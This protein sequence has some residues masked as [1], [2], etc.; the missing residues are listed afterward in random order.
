[1]TGFLS[2]ALSRLPTYS[3]TRTFRFALVL[4]IGCASA[5][6]FP[7]KAQ[8]VPP[9]TV[10]FQSL[11]ED[12]MNPDQL[13]LWPS[14]AFVT[15]QA[16]SYNRLAKT[17]S[18]PAGWFANNDCSHFIRMDTVGDRHEWVMMDA[19]GPGCVDR[20][21]TGGKDAT[22]TVR[23]YLDGSATPALEGPLAG[24]LFGKD[25]V[26]GGPLAY[27]TPHEAGNM[28]LPIPYAKH[29]K[30][31][32]DEVDPNNATAPSPQRWYN[33][34]YRTYAPQT[35]VQT[36]TKQDY[37]DQVDL[38]K[39]VGDFLAG[40]WAQPEG[41]SMTLDK[42][43]SL[44][45]PGG[46][47]AIRQLN[48]N[49]VGLA[50]DQII[51]AHRALVLI[52]HFDG[53]QTIWCPVSDFFGSGVGVNVLTNWV[54]HVTQ[55]GMMST[56]WVMPYRQ[57]G[58]LTLHNFGAQKVTVHL[59]AIVN[60]WN[61]SNRS[62]HFHGTWRDQTDIPTRP[63]SDWNY[64][65]ATGKGVYVGDTLSTYNPADGWFGEG[66]EKIWVDDDTFPSHFGTG[67]E[68]YYGSAWSFPGLYQSS[69]SNLILRPVTHGYIGETSVTRVRDLDAIT[70]TKSLKHDMEIWSWKDCKMDYT[71]ANYW[72]A[73]P[74]T[75]STTVPQPAAVVRPLK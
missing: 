51:A 7:G 64:L 60:L 54:C 34:E 27:K 9:S 41:T 69:F 45:L 50:P 37:T 16:S 30:I 48:F 12:M 71:V 40:P 66:D 6:P 70:F 20:F 4:L 32:Y 72:Y 33:I 29:C 5:I 59:E 11:L 47:H 28:Y 39:K 73:L 75:T 21:W 43:I 22:G 13:A 15:H 67:T 38:V 3:R 62:M 65:T 25:F 19:A 2:C 46:A 10:T 52:A 24:L 36:F 53:E 18:D 35:H 42:E 63:Y 57:L 56:R 55:D 23:F 26:A 68:D 44:Q 74:G 1:M 31:T 58:S 14:P 49:L 17:P 8:T 61:W